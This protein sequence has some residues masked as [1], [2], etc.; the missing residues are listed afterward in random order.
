MN[1]KTTLAL[2]ALAAIGSVLV[3]LGTHLPAWL[4]LSPSRPSAAD[5][6]SEELARLDASKLKQV[7]IE[8]DGRVT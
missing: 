3:A 6:T 2:L 7:T 4:D 1:L 8:K 5:P